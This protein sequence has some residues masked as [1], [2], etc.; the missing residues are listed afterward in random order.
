[1]ICSAQVPGPRIP[2]DTKLGMAGA[3]VCLL[4]QE[5]SAVSA[6]PFPHKKEASAM[7]TLLCYAQPNSMR[8]AWLSDQVPS[9]IGLAAY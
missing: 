4:P 1:M 5:L 9:F 7:L 8:R 6:R 3:P 2:Y